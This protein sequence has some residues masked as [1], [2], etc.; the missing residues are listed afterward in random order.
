MNG[1]L[2]LF[3]NIVTIFNVAFINSFKG[4][5]IGVHYFVVPFSNGDPKMIPNSLTKQLIPTDLFNDKLF[6]P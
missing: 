1:S 3:A 5:I 2:L 6:L 4:R